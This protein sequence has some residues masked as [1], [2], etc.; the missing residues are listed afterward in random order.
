MDGKNDKP[1]AR[2]QPSGLKCLYEPGQKNHGHLI[3]QG[4][5]HPNP[6]LQ[7]PENF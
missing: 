4:Y 6:K 7:H 2:S 1:G 5:K 3:E